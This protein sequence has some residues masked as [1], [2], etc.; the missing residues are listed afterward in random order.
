[1]TQMHDKDRRP[2]LPGDICIATDAM[3]NACVGTALE[4]CGG[5]ILIQI[6]REDGELVQGVF[7]PHRVQAIGS[8]EPVSEGQVQRPSATILDFPKK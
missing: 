2:V 4:E 8:R 7:P 3:G 5:R 6:D 1:M